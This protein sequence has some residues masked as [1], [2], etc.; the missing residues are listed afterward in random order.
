MSQTVTNVP[1]DAAPTHKG[2]FTQM[3]NALL[4]LLGNGNGGAVT[5]GDLNGTGAFGGGGGTPL[6]FTPGPAVP[7]YPGGVPTPIPLTGFT[8]TSLFSGVFLSWTPSSYTQG[9]GEDHVQVWGCNVP[10]GVVTSVTFA[11]AVQIGTTQGGSFIDAGELGVTRAY[12]LVS[13]ARNSNIQTVPTGGTNG[14]QCTIGLVGNANLGPY[15]VEAGNI[16]SGAVTPA[17]FATGTY[18]SFIGSSLPGL[19]DSTYPAGTIFVNTTDYK[20]YRSSGATWVKTVDGNDITANSI[21][22][23][24]VVAGGLA[25][26]TI[27]AGSAAIQ[28]GAIGTAM[29]GSLAVTDAKIA[30]LNVSKLLAGS[31]AVGQYIQSSNYVASTQGFTIQ[32]SG[33][34]EFANVDLRGNL[35]GNKSGFTDSTAGFFIGKY[36][37]NYTLNVGNATNYFKWDGSNLTITGSMGVYD[38]SSN[39]VGSIGYQ[40]YTNGSFIHNTCSWWGNQAVTTA[41]AIT[42]VS[43]NADTIVAWS[44]GANGLTATGGNTAA[45]VQ[46]SG[47]TGVSGTS[48]HGTTGNPGNG[49]YGQSY[50]GGKGYGVVGYG[51]FGNSGIYGFSDTSNGGI[52]AAAGSSGVIGVT[53]SSAGFGVYGQAAAAGTGVYGVCSSGGIGIEG[54]ASSGWGVYG[55]SSSSVGVYGL[56]TSNIGVQGICTANVGVY[57]SGATGIYG[58]GTV[59]AGRFDGPTFCNGTFAANGN[60]PQSKYTVPAAPNVGVD[61]LATTQTLVNALRTAL[62]NCG[63]CQ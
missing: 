15:I 41:S 3:R 12:W 55:V 23:G 11:N 63:I 5:Y 37:T 52:P 62:I 59:Y 49:L 58:S 31:L 40:T 6:T 1:S 25:A 29:I 47:G 33:Y 57:G 43:A 14:V 16:A 19:P 45:G 42:A 32:A 17:S 22:A 4:E 18:P 46:G 60:A 44:T 36:L 9:G 54:N 61:T 26:N 20:V 34:A 35:Y 51:V 30:S 39:N 8:A 56:S 48:T 2:F 28:N 13:V 38:G 50:S 21:Y 10:G 27:V 53:N 7:S 24:Q